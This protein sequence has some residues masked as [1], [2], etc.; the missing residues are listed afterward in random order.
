MREVLRG[1]EGLAEAA[2]RM[3]RRRRDSGRNPL[4]LP[5]AYAVRRCGLSASAWAPAACWAEACASRF[6]RSASSRWLT[7]SAVTASALTRRCDSTL[8]RAFEEASRLAPA[9][10]SVGRVLR[11]YASRRFH[12][13]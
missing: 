12:E 9:L 1:H 6:L 5:V 4:R 11:R 7:V 3:R 10:R 2:H 8:A 13:R